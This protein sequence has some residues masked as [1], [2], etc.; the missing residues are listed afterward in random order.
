MTF[1][2]LVAEVLVLTKRPD[3]QTKIESAVRGATLKAHQ[4]DYHYRDLVETGVQ[5]P[6]ALYLQSFNPKDIFANY[7][8]FKYLRWHSGVLETAPGQFYKYEQIGNSDDSY[9]AIKD[10]VFYSAG[11]LIQIRSST[12]LQYA[13]FGC[14]VH[15][16]IIPNYSFSSWIAVE[17]PWLI[18]YEAA[19]VL[20]LGIGFQEQ[21]A[22]MAQLFSEQ[23]AIMVISEGTDEVPT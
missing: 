12:P 2:E 17:Y 3:L 6:E 22:S 19:R 4:M 14:Y 18:I 7:R 9:G 16:I 11:Q 13:L 5:F 10:D 20:F 1:E 23:R 8:K 21:S 15:P